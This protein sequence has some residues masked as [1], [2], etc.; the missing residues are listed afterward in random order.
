[1]HAR[2]RIFQQKGIDAV[3]ERCYNKIKNVLKTK[4][5]VSS[6][7]LEVPEFVIGYPIYE[8]GECIVFV[9]RHMEGN[10]YK[11]TYLFPRLL[12][13]SWAD[14]IERSKMLTD[15]ST[16]SFNVKPSGKVVLSLI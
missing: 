10:G 9:K 15:M 8:L 2:R 16:S 11:V 3:V 1:M 14:A 7:V 5:R 4:A 12:I 6:C 13:V